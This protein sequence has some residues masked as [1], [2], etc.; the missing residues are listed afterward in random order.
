MAQGFPWNFAL[1]SCHTQAWQLIGNPIPPP[2]AYVLGSVRAGRSL[3][4]L[5][6]ISWWRE[7]GGR[8]LP[9]V[10]PC[11]RWGLGSPARRP[12]LSPRSTDPQEI[13]DCPRPQARAQRAEGILGMGSPRWRTPHVAMVQGR[14]AGE[15][16]SPIT[17]W[18]DPFRRMKLGI[19]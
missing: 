11:E 18:I 3:P 14:R 5:G 6:E 7:L 13:K 10:L 17:I 15:G 9:Q 19:P 1:P 12:G 8:W 4:G 16:E 2:M